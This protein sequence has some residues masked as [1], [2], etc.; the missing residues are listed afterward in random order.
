MDSPS[1]SLSFFLLLF[2]SIFLVPS[3]PSHNIIIDEERLYFG[4]SRA[5]RR[6]R[7]SS[8]PPLHNILFI[9]VLVIISIGS[10]YLSKGTSS[11]P[12][13]SLRP[14]R[15]RSLPSPS[16]SLMPSGDHLV[17]AVFRSSSTSSTKSPPSYTFPLLNFRLKSDPSLLIVS[18]RGPSSSGA[19]ASAPW[20]SDA[21]L[22]IVKDPIRSAGRWHD[23]HLHI[24]SKL[25]V[26]FVCIEIAFVE[27]RELL[28]SS[29][30]LIAVCYGQI[31]PLRALSARSSMRIRPCSRSN[32]MAWN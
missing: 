3:H 11:S 16:P 7:Q 14:R 23:W 24:T 25:L 31:L 13:P 12:G 9:S 10:L 4:C 22:D 8:I 18:S 26:S 28:E 15:R 6:R 32:S 5:D 30:F 20:T 21:A 17:F 27:I 19:S 2:L 1:P 29:A